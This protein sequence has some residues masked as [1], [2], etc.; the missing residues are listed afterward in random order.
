MSGLEFIEGFS[1]EPSKSS[2]FNKRDEFGTPFM[3]T[4]ESCFKKCCK[5]YKKKS[6]SMCK[7]CPKR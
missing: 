4:G 3:T 2:P 1:E 6:K 5:K 7:S